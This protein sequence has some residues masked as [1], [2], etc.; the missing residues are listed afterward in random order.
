MDDDGTQQREGIVQ[1][2]SM[3]CNHAARNK[4]QLAQPLQQEEARLTIARPKRRLACIGNGFITITSR[5]KDEPKQGME[6][7]LRKKELNES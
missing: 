6:H 3:A 1:R 4:E 5:W 7:H 2:G